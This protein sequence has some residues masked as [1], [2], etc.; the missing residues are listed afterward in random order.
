MEVLKNLYVYYLPTNV[1]F[2]LLE[3]SFI[4][5]PEDDPKGESKR[6]VLLLSL[7]YDRRGVDVTWHFLIQY[8]GYQ[9]HSAKLFDSR[10]QKKW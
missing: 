7:E 6:I 8:N 3:D 2:I 4:S 9:A 1:N 5:W 10:A